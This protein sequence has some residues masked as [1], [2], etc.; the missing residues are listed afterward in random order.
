MTIVDAHLD[1]AFSALRYGRDLRQPIANLR[2]QESPHPQRGTA[3]VT[4]PALRAGGVGLVFGTVY[5]TPRKVQDLFKDPLYTPMTYTTPDEAYR[6][7]M[8][9][10]DY[11]ERLADDET[12]G[13]RLVGDVAVLDEVLASQGTERPLIGIVP[14]MEG[15][16]PIREPKEL[17]LWVERGLRLVGLAWDDTRYAAGAWRN[18]REGITPDGFRLLEVMA[19][20]GLILDLTHMSEQATL[21][22][23]ERYAGPV[24]ATHANARS[25]VPG[26]RQ[27]GDTQI[28]LLGERDG[29]IGVV[30]YNR[31]LRAGQA[32]GDPKDQVTLDHVV[33][34]IDHIC[35]LLGDATHV[36]IGSD[37]DGGFG[38]E[39]IPAE[40]DNAADLHLIADRLRAYGYAEGHISGIM[41]GNWLRVMRGVLPG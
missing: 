23:L 2:A 19:D 30:L 8:Q 11:Y 33:A 41:G 3:T 18:N 28:R 22:A 14:L 1:L 40:L 39:D 29:V 9:Q 36:G 4:L 7:G 5:C 32:K 37:F 25:L 20:F 10:L 21:Q 31:F 15:A 24:V 16:D 35:Q 26:E 17:E 27:L 38:A 34:H 12:S 6:L 13:V